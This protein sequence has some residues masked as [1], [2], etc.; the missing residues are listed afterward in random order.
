MNKRLQGCAG[1]QWTMLRQ[2]GAL[3]ALQTGSER[4][5]D[6]PLEPTGFWTSRYQQKPTKDKPASPSQLQRTWAQHLR[7]AQSL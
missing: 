3:S 7:V 6:H 4:W 5:Q 2:A 1:V